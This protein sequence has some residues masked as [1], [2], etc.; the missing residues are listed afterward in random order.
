M[1]CRAFFLINT[2][3]FSDIGTL[4]LNW[5]PV[6]LRIFAVSHLALS[7][8]SHVPPSRSSKCHLNAE[9]AL[10]LHFM[11]SPTYKTKTQQTKQTTDKQDTRQTTTTATTTTTTTAET[12]VLWHGGEWVC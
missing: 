7:R 6:V 11:T 2:S 5:E 1:R 3:L 8:L 12:S 9:S 4:I 10:V